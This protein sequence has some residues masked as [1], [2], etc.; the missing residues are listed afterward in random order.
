MYTT[1]FDLDARTL[2]K[3][4]GLSS[5][6]GRDLLL[7]GAIVAGCMI[8]GAW[9]GRPLFFLSVIPLAMFLFFWT[10]MMLRELQWGRAH[11]ASGEQETQRPGFV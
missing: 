8:Y 1:V 6:G 10:P 7:L 4:Y 2:W 11:L 3:E 9:R 5:A